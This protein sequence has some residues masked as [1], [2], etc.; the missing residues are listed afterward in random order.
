MDGCEFF[1]HVFESP[2]ISCIE[3]LIQ[4]TNVPCLTLCAAAGVLVCSLVHSFVLHDDD[5]LTYF[6]FLCHECR[7]LML[8]L[9][10]NDEPPRKLK[11]EI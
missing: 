2:C 10:H 1:V 4:I 9:T 11:M 7:L 6:S 3:F 8:A 5:D